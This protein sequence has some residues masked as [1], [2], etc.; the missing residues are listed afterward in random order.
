MIDLQF[1]QVF[2]YPA[3]GIYY[4]A[5]EVGK[6]K[7]KAAVVRLQEAAPMSPITSAVVAIEVVVVFLLLSFP[8]D[9]SAC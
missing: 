6:K 4:E 2:L 7:A 9:S 5:D 1:R 3:R 8:F